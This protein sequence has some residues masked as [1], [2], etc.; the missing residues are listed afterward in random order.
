MDIMSADK[1]EA[2]DRN[3]ELR[4]SS[5]LLNE[6]TIRHNSVMRALKRMGEEKYGLC[7]ID[8]N[9]IEEDRLKANPAA[10]TCKEHMADEDTMK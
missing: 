1:N 4:I 6:L 10:R 2:A 9:P 7:E 3:E 8:N 5:I